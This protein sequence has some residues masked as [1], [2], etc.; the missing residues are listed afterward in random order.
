MKYLPLAL[1]VLC[2][3]SLGC[4]QSTPVMTKAP[5]GYHGGR[6]PLR[7]PGGDHHQARDS[8][9]QGPV[10]SPIHERLFVQSAAAPRP[11]QEV[12]RRQERGSGLGCQR[13]ARATVSG[14]RV[15]ATET[16]EMKWFRIALGSAVAITSVSAT[17]WWAR[18]APG[19][20]R[21][22]HRDPVTTRFRAIKAGAARRR[23]ATRRVT[24]ADA[25]AP[26]RRSLGRSSAGDRDAAP[27]PKAVVQRADHRIRPHGDWRVEDPS[28]S[29]R[30]P[31]GRSA[32][33][34]KGPTECKCTIS[35][36]AVAQ[37]CR[38]AALPTWSSP[39]PPRCRSVVRE[40]GHHLDQRSQ[41]AGDSFSRRRQGGSCAGRVADGL[42]RRHRRRR[43]G[44]QGGRLR[45][46]RSRGRLQNPLG[47]A[48]RSQRESELQADV[49]RA[50]DR[51]GML[52]GY[53]FTVRVGNG[54]PLGT[55]RTRLNILTSLEPKTPLEVE[56][57]ATRPGPIRILSAGT[58]HWSPENGLLN[59]GRFRHEDGYRTEVPA[60]IYHM[61]G[62]FRVL[63][64]K[65]S[66]GFVKVSVEPNPG[67]GRESVG[68]SARRAIRVR[69][70]A[71]LA[72]GQLL[73]AKA[74]PRHARN[75]SSG[76]EDDRLRSAV[77]VA[78]NS[79]A[80]QL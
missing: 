33:V 17:I 1:V 75:Q 56:L 49:G 11:A 32:G 69:G 23:A 2:S 71:R 46:V 12:R 40:V 8:R 51:V 72:A 55:F 39:G 25:A 18:Y 42:A 31:G 54:I 50:L 20:E 13:V 24:T 4:G 19:I 53:E 48:V 74:G 62:P 45:G 43:P 37:S 6:R 29:H 80:D 59:L 14:G 30:E 34:A 5:P 70:V 26:K 73:H 41:A 16:T 7:L 66:D 28:F 47:R 78:V 65:S 67:S 27:F 38:R 22:R 15:T 68:R 44:G 63:G 57:T 64:V 36:L 10:S 9:G 61:Q 77:R 60:Y 52:G 35:N 21:R 3:V 58:A 76:A 79:S